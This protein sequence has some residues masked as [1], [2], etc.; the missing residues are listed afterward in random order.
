MSSSF[1]TPLAGSPISFFLL[2]S[3]LVCWRGGI[4]LRDMLH[5]CVQLR[6]ALREPGQPRLP[7]PFCHYCFP[8]RLSPARQHTALP[9]FKS[10][11]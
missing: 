3:L 10:P 8:Y 11:F 9:R 6:S 7:C 4:L 1:A 5:R 2:L